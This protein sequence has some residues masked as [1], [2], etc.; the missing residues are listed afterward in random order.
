MRADN[1]SPIAMLLVTPVVLDHNRLGSK[2]TVVGC[3]HDLCPEERRPCAFPS[4]EVCSRFAALQSMLAAEQIV[5]RSQRCD[6]I[7]RWRTDALP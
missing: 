7:S 2:A 3:Q 4:G 6:P 1:C 5:G